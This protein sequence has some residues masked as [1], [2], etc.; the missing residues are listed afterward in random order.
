VQ[1]PDFS[2]QALLVTVFDQLTGWKIA[3]AGNNKVSSP[4]DR[5]AKTPNLPSNTIVILAHNGRMLTMVVLNQVAHPVV[6]FRFRSV[7]KRGGC[8]RIT[9][10]T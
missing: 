8:I 3:A 2:L 7:G 4:E 1:F 5:G 10:F 9:R 6:V